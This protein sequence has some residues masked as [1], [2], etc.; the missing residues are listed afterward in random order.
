MILIILRYRLNEVYL[1][2]IVVVMSVHITKMVLFRLRAK[3]FLF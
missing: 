3:Y 2:T 1:F